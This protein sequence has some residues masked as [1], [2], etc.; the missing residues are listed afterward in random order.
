MTFVNAYDL[1]TL[2]AWKPH[3]ATPVTPG[4]L[5]RWSGRGELATPPPVGARVNVRI[6]GFGWGEVLAYFTEHG[7]LGLKVR[8]DQRPSWH[9]KQAPG[10]AYCLVF[11]SE[12]EPLPAG[13]T[14]TAHVLSEA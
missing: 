7:F 5:P 8:P 10:R 14:P 3:D 13:P 2:P 11:G 4:E 9:L 6:N 1:T 12:C